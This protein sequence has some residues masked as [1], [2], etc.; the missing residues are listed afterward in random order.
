MSRALALI[1]S[2][3]PDGGRVVTVRGE[4]DVGSTGALRDWLARASDRGRRSVVVDLRGVQF[5]AVSGLYV[6]C[7]EQH[8]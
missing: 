5:L 8:R 3:A 4:V 1:E 6:L 2:D 7:D